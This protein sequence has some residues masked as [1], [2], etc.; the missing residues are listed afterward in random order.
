MLIELVF[1]TFG[2]VKKFKKSLGPVRSKPL[3]LPPP[4]VQPAQEA[5]S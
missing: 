4:T 2:I 5:V 1:A 3:P